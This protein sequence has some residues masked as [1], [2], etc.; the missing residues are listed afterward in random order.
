M[1]EALLKP[2]FRPILQG[3]E[4][5]MASVDELQAQVQAVKESLQA[6]ID[7][8]AADVEALKAQSGGID[9]S[10][11]DPISQGLADLK[12]SLDSLDPVPDSE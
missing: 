10:A 5:I 11:L 2:L 8:V 6:A 3:I 1:F 12:G 7:R 9:P 4:A